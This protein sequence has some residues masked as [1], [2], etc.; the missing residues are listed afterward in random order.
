MIDNFLWD[1]EKTSQKI[2]VKKQRQIIKSTWDFRVELAQDEF[3]R[4]RRMSEEEKS[5]WKKDRSRST[6]WREKLQSMVLCVCR[7]N[8][9]A[10]FSNPIPDNDNDSDC[11]RERE[12]SRPSIFLSIYLLRR[13]R[14]ETEWNRVHVPTR[15]SLI[16]RV[17]GFWG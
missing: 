9:A 11:G 17:Y 3:S 4:R 12:R 2:A 7:R 5:E 1:K 10:K 15:T 8:A 14:G 16:L 13:W 6:L